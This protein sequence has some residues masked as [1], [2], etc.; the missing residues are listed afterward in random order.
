M[1]SKG[2]AL[3]AGPAFGHVQHRGLKMADS[4]VRLGRP[5]ERLGALRLRR[6][7][8]RGRSSRPFEASASRGENPARAPG[9]F[10]GGAVPGEGG[11]GVCVCVWVCVCVHSADDAATGQFV[12][13]LSGSNVPG[14]GVL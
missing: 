14:L 7:N 5:I 9:G 13:T 3:L 12:A 2:K 10:A 4:D 6:E 1:I 8:E 11:H